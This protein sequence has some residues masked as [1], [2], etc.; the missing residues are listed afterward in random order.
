VP[1]RHL[2][3]PSARPCLFGRM[4]RNAL[5][6][7]KARGAKNNGKDVANAKRHPGR[8]WR[9]FSGLAIS[10]GALSDIN[11]CLCEA[12]KHPCPDQT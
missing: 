2:L 8:R 11:E 12:A 10:I 5:I 1:Y 9:R 4:R 6:A 3:Q 7:P